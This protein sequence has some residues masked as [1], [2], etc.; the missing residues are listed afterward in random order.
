MQQL[1]AKLSD[2]VVKER[3]GLKI[4]RRAAKSVLM[5]CN[6]S[7]ALSAQTRKEIELAVRKLYRA[8]TLPNPI[9]I[10]GF[11]IKYLG[12]SHFRY[13]INEVFLEGSYCFT[14]ETESP[15]IFDC[16]SNIGASVLFFKKIYPKSRIVAFE[17]DPFTFDV[18]SENIAVNCLSNVQARRGALGA[19]DG[20]VEF[21]RDEAPESSSLLMSTIRERHSGPAV[22]VP[23][24]RLSQFISSDVDL[25]KI[26][27]EGAERDVLHDL[28][29]TGKLKYARRIHLEY[30][31]HIDTSK[32][33]LSSLL[34][35]M[36]NHGY[37]YQMRSSPWKWPIE[38]EFQDVSIYFYKKT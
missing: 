6:P 28:A 1:K 9:D 30:H 21:Y 20:E 15:L 14:A 18:L 17:P 27:I 26:D 5:D 32:D 24:F 29:E 11:R 10:L 16:G 36:E 38:S 25:L 8:R 34:R 23:A 3:A 7:R 12:E 33:D 31:H 22:K 13:L 37:G 19:V 35:L 2:F 4:A